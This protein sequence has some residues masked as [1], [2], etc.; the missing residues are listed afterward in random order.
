MYL[1]HPTV[2]DQTE[3]AVAGITAAWRNGQPLFHD[4]D[5]PWTYSLSYGP[6]LYALLRPLHALIGDPL[7]AGKLSGLIWA[8]AGLFAIHRVARASL[9]A[10]DA[11]RIV[12]FACLGLMAFG[13]TSVG[14]RGDAILF[15]LVGLAILVLPAKTAPLASATIRWA[16][17]GAIV[18][19]AMGI[20]APTAIYFTS[21]L[22]MLIESKNPFRLTFVAAV[23]G[24]VFLAL[25]FVVLPDV[26]VFNFAAFLQA[27]AGHPHTLERAVGPI[28]WASLM[29]LP[30]AAAIALAEDRHDW[31]TKERRS[32]AALVLTMAALIAVGAKVGAGRH[33]VIPFIPIAAW[34]WTRSQAGLGASTSPSHRTL[35]EA[36]V[37]VLLAL[38]LLLGSIH[39]RGVASRLD[40][41]QARKAR[42]EIEV[43]L[44]R[45]SGRSISMGYA[46]PGELSFLRSLVI[47]ENHPLVLDSSAIMDATLVGWSAN[48]QILA[49]FE[50]CLVESWISPT[51]SPPFDLR[52]HYAQDK[53]T[54]GDKIHVVF[55]ASYR[56]AYSTGLYTVWHCK[57][58]VEG[59]P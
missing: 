15:G 25:P 11:L 44:D 21:V 35:W 6:V 42:G 13:E 56:P 41:E 55:E 12:G 20:K 37:A 22:P 54:F 4:F 18:G 57:N 48:E 52:N 17:I 38:L 34:F 39:L 40:G 2:A 8:A 1:L 50:D 24:L 29:I 49:S 16:L 32:L 27:I 9:P 3:A 23:A 10:K 28:V 30:A 26:D 45:E 36:I 58:E 14:G 46:E 7:S 5:A 19:T 51:D 31:V 33:H 43:I 59:E 53:N 47:A